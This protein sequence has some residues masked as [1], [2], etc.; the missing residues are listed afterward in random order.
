MFIYSQYFFFFFAD[1]A[2]QFLRLRAVPAWV[3][4]TRA[5]ST[6]LWSSLFSHASHFRNHTYLSSVSSFS[7]LPSVTTKLIKAHADLNLLIKRKFYGGN[8][9]T[10]LV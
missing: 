1:A 3:F 7:P 4:E 8:P 10:I 5:L 2:A 9:G 6:C